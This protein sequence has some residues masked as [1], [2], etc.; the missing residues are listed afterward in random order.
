MK[1]YRITFRTGTYESA[2]RI[3]EVEDFECEQDA[4]DKMI[5]ELKRRSELYSSRSEMSGDAPDN[6]SETESEIEAEAESEDEAEAESGVQNG[7]DIDT[8]YETEN[9]TEDKTPG[10]LNESVSGI[11]RDLAG[12]ARK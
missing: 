9:I 11:E 10:G 3:V 12:T 1:K 6:I 5:D 7:A 8:E 4:L 2:T